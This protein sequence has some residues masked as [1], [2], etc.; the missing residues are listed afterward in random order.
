MCMMCQAIHASPQRA[1]REAVLKGE[2][3]PAWAAAQL[4]AAGI[5]VGELEDRLRQQSTWWER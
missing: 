5:D 4:Q 2:V 1:F 3:P